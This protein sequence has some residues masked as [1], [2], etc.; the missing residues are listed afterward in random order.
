MSESMA[1]YQKPRELGIDLLKFICMLGVVGLHT[2]RDL[3]T[4]VLYNPILYYLSRFAMPVFFMINGY[5]IMKKT[6]FDFKYYKKKILNMVRLL[7]IWGCI[8]GVYSLLLCGDSL[9]QAVF[10]SIKC[11]LGYYIVPFWFMFTF[12]LIYTILL[13]GFNWIKRNIKLLT[14]I[15]IGVCLVIDIC[16]FVNICNGGGFVT[17]SI[18]Q[19]F[20]LWTWLMYF[21]LGYAVSEVKT[22]FSATKKY[23]LLAVTSVASCIIQYLYCFKLA[24]IIN[25]GYLY[26]NI[27]IIAWSVLIFVIF[28][29][30][31]YANKAGKYILFFSSNSFGIFLMHE[32]ITAYF[33]LT[34]KV[35][36][37]VESTLLWIFIIVVT[38]LL[39]ALLRKIPYIKRAFEY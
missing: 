11:M 21:F 36:T 30:I 23:L 29:N 9:K 17:A 7:F 8:S 16:S 10:N 34:S 12:I 20:K 5:L 32:Y 15:L 18:N 26:N 27:F 37:A 13:I 24:G 39:T 19:R 35:S 31:R 38:L 28:K 1:K 14:T 25:S 3:A 6:E 33:G 22:N 4:N 2:Q